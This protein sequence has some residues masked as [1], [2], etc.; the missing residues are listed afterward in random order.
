VLEG[1]PDPHVPLPLTGELVLVGTDIAELRF[2]E[3]FPHARR[4]PV[5]RGGERADRRAR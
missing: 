3:E 1:N 2:S 4:R 5:L